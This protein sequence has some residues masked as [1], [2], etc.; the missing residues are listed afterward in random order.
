VA[1]A[2]VLLLGGCT[3]T[4]PQA[5]VPPVTTPTSSESQDVAVDLDKE[6]RTIVDASCDRAYEIGVTESVV[7]SDTRLV[8]VPVTD[9]YNDFTAAV[10]NND[11]GLTPIWSTEEFAVCI[12][13]INFSMSEEGGSE[14]AIT[15]SGDFASGQLR[16]EYT[17][18]DYGVFVNDYVIVDGLITEVTTMTPE[19]TSAKTVRYGMPSDA[20]VRHFQE[21]IDAF[22]ADQ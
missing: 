11:A 6:F 4:E 8:L 2:A 22:L 21:A 15:V 14:Y 18:E 5:T 20:D 16:S 17:V 13:S 10:V 12:D 1:L 19:S 3:T 9:A 7:G